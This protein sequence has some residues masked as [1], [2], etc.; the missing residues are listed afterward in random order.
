MELLWNNLLPAGSWQVWT[1]KGNKIKMVPSQC[2][3]VTF[4]VSLVVEITSQHVWENR[5][6]SGKIVIAT[7]TKIPENISMD[8]S[9]N[10]SSSLIWGM[11]H[12]FSSCLILFLLCVICSSP[13]FFFISQTRTS[14]LQ[15]PPILKRANLKKNTESLPSSIPS[16]DNFR[17]IHSMHVEK[18]KGMAIVLPS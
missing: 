9:Y 1:A 13:I 4:Q 18:G 5:W 12:A 16:L 15:K 3:K 14:A 11:T 2:F 10:I 17:A 6:V 8:F 7:G